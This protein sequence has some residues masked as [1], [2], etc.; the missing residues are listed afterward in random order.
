MVPS[1]RQWIEEVWT[2]R[3]DGSKVRT[4]QQGIFVDGQLVVTRRSI[5]VYDK[6]G[7]LCGE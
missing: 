5:D 3:A 7:Q 2:P 1:R 6:D 4:V